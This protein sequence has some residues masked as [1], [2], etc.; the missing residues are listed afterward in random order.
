MTLCPARGEEPAS[1]GVEEDA[2]KFSWTTGAA[3]ICASVVTAQAQSQTAPTSAQPLPH[4]G[5]QSVMVTGCVAKADTAATANSAYILTSARM[6]NDSPTGTA[7]PSQEDSR[8]VAGRGNSTA[9]ATSA[10]ARYALESKST[11]LSRYVGQRVEVS[12]RLEASN[13]AGSSGSTATNETSSATPA[14]VSVESVR[15]IAASCTQG[16]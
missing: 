11:D 6:S 1:V 9:P 8:N 12:G 4:G 2:M 15:T 16:Q 5:N 3:I 14:L 10:G 7:Q 13:S